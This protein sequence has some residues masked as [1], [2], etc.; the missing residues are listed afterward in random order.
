MTNYMQPNY[1]NSGN[2]FYLGLSD[3]SQNYYNQQYP[4]SNISQN[5]INYQ[6]HNT[7]IDPNFPYYSY[8]VDD[9]SVFDPYR[10]MA[11]QNDPNNPYNPLFASPQQVLNTEPFKHY[12]E[13][14]KSNAKK[15]SS[16]INNKKEKL[17]KCKG[18]NK[19]AIEPEDKTNQKLE[20]ASKKEVKKKKSSLKKVSAIEVNSEKNFVNM[21]SPFKKNKEPKEI[22]KKINGHFS[23]LEDDIEEKVDIIPIEFKKVPKPIKH[24]TELHQNDALEPKKQLF[25]SD[26]IEELSKE[27]PVKK[28][29]EIGKK[30]EGSLMEKTTDEIET[31]LLSEIK[32][33]EKLESKDP[34]IMEKKPNSVDPQEEYKIHTLK[35]DLQKI[36]QNTEVVLKKFVP[37]NDLKSNLT[38]ERDSKIKINELSKNLSQNQSLSI[39][40]NDKNRSAY[41]RMFILGDMLPI[42]YQDERTLSLLFKITR[43]TAKNTKA[44]ICII[45]IVTPKTVIWKCKYGTHNWLPPTIFEENKNYS[46]DA[47]VISQPPGKVY[48]IPDLLKDENFS[49]TLTSRVGLSFYAGIALVSSYGNKFGVLSIRHPSHENQKN[50]VVN[51]KQSSFNLATLTEEQ[52]DILKENSQ[53][54]S[55]LMEFSATL[56]SISL[57]ESNSIFLKKLNN[58]AESCVNFIQSTDNKPPSVEKT[59]I[60]PLEA[61]QST[62]NNADHIILLDILTNSSGFT[63]SVRAKSNCFD[64]FETK[65]NVKGKSGLVIGSQSIF[66]DLCGACL[67][68]KIFSSERPEDPGNSLK[69]NEENSSLSK[70]TELKDENKSETSKQQKVH[71][72][73]CEILWIKNRPIAILCSLF[74]SE[75]RVI[76]S[77]E[78]QILSGSRQPLCTILKSIY[79]FSFRAITHEFGFDLLRNFMPD[80]IG[81]PGPVPD[82][83]KFPNVKDMNSF[84]VTEISKPPALLSDKASKN[85][86]F[87][88]KSDIIPAMLV[89]EPSISDSAVFLLKKFIEID[90]F[91]N[92]A[93]DDPLKINDLGNNQKN[94]ESLTSP[95]TGALDSPKSMFEVLTQK[96]GLQMTSKRI[97]NLFVSVA[98]LPNSTANPHSLCDLC[99]ELILT[100]KTYE[101]Q[102]KLKVGAHIGLHADCI[103][104]LKCPTDITIQEGFA[105][106]VNVAYFLSGIHDDQITASSNFRTS[107][108]EMYEFQQRVPFQ[109]RGLEPWST[110][111]LVGK[112][113]ASHRHGKASDHGVSNSN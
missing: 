21:E 102:T 76:S 43:R 34:E 4:F 18:D 27:I 35:T 52:E 8:V 41:E 6:T 98:N 25:N 64:T 106:I 46:M 96:H 24:N 92:Y 90:D 54:I 23:K 112:T 16:K 91:E 5:N 84:D 32:K 55:S 26:K 30:I 77:Q 2:E 73:V 89:I 101:K 62:L 103:Y 75:S 74:F 13:K 45:S 28:M 10:M 53:L 38:L 49:Q 7:P 87:Q 95:L 97:G 12:R 59:K 111:I 60:D 17:P 50:T 110:F 67:D 3:T 63:T 14:K 78:L 39:L 40:T 33:E 68:F 108:S 70:P 80:R 93:K 51:E 109:H 69:S 82:T 85:P 22:T 79:E 83:K 58:L 57:I 48:V 65:S 31:K 94:G 9:S 99:I 42:K 11:M 71:K 81:D 44:A 107:I 37:Q 56:N 113:S 19:H 47:W 100:L 72:S 104:G 86:Q 36:S 88:H 1:L 66:T 61:M 105:G 20:N 15:V 29:N